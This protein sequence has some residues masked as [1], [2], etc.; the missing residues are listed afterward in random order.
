[1]RAAG[2]DVR[3]LVQEP[4]EGVGIVAANGSFPVRT[5]RASARLA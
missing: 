2:V 4:R 1:V 3:T 5:H